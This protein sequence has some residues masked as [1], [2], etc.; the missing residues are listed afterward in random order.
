MIDTLPSGATQGLQI[1]RWKLFRIER[2]IP[3]D[4][5]TRWFLSIVRSFD[6]YLVSRLARNFCLDLTYCCLRVVMGLILGSYQCVDMSQL[7]LCPCD[8][9]AVSGW[10]GASLKCSLWISPLVSA[11]NDIRRWII[12]AFSIK[13][14]RLPM[15]LVSSRRNGKRNFEFANS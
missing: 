15:P 1:T 3:L 13:S 12:Q 9:E 4:T 2:M 14:D 10:P 11:E 5:K 6:T 7:H 8:S